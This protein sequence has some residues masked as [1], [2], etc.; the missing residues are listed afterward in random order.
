MWEAVVDSSVV[1]LVRVVPFAGLW[2]PFMMTTRSMWL[3]L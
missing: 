2:F 1:H 3:V